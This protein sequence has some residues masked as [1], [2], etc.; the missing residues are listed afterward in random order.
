MVWLKKKQKAST[1]PESYKEHLKIKGP[2]KQF[3]STSLVISFSL[4][5]QDISNN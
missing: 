5:F 3:T 4:N 2:Q 1:G